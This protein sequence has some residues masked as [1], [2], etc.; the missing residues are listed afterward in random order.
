MEVFNGVIL[1]HLDENPNLVYSIL[2][3]HKAF[4]D[5]GTF[6]LAR[7]LREVKRIQK[8]K[9]E[10]AQEKLGT[11]KGKNASTER[12]DEEP[13]EEKARLLRTETRDALGLSTASE[14]E[15]RL[16]RQS[17]TPPIGRLSLEGRGQSDEMPSGQPLMSP[18]TAELP[19][20]LPGSDLDLS[21]KARG[22]MR[23][24]PRSTSL[25]TTS[26]LERIA[27]AGIGRNG[28][29]PTQEWVSNCR[30]ACC[31]GF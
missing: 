10:Q 21:E 4:E 2:R 22:K 16:P 23:E 25:D 29:I 11:V 9:E 28:F 17:Q 20:S 24:R 14:Q 7:G 15:E 1:H 18:T 3:S 8:A 12:D 19:M 5:L 27:A 26:S 31:L 6:T 13:H 30:A